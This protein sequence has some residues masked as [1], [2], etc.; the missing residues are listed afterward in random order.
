MS[1]L[2]PK[3]QG[4]QMVLSLKIRLP[5]AFPQSEGLFMAEEEATPWLTD[6]WGAPGKISTLYDC[7]GGAMLIS[8]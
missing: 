4:E 8:F 3:F 6:T 5:P 2:P 1:H 7:G